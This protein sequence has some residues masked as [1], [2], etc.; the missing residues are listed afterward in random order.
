M[1]HANMVRNVVAALQET[2][3]APA[4]PERRKSSTF[5]ASKFRHLDGKRHGFLQ[6]YPATDVSTYANH[7]GEYAV[8]EHQ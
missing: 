3:Y 4:E 8:Y 5:S 7:E 6:F 1:H 2:M